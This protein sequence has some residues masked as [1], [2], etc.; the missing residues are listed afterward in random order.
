V[1]SS[2]LELLPPPKVFPSSMVGG[3]YLFAPLFL[4][5]VILMALFKGDFVTFAF[6]GF[7]FTRFEGLN[8]LEGIDMLDTD[9]IEDE[10]DDEEED[11]LEDEFDDELEELL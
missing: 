4:R 5:L 1:S 8:V 3:T 2:S 9:S 7:F 6:E 10:L 11:E